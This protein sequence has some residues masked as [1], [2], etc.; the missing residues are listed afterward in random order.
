MEHRWYMRERN[1]ADPGPQSATDD[2]VALYGQKGLS[3]SVGGALRSALQLL[4]IRI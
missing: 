4:K 2:Y 1:G 3:G